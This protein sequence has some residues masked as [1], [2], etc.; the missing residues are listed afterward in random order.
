MLIVLEKVDGK[1]NE[2]FLELMGAL[3]DGKYVLNVRSLNPLKTER[4]FQNEYFAL[5]D[6]VRDVTG[7]AKYMIHISFK[8]ERKVESTTGFSLQDW[9]DYIEAFK[10]YYYKN[11]D[12]I[13]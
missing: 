8:K 1:F 7:E 9:V 2:Q 4:E 11:A 3:G 10:W 5:I 12:I 6:Q 13:L